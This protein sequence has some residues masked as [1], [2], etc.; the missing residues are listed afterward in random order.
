MSEEARPGRGCLSAL[1]ILWEAPRS[2]NSERL[3]VTFVF[4]D[5]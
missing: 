4:P 2:Y 1:S 3:E 5:F